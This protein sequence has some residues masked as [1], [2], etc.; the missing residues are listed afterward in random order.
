MTIWSQTGRKQIVEPVANIIKHCK[1]VTVETEC[2]KDPNKMNYVETCMSQTECNSWNHES[3]NKMY[4][5]NK[6]MMQT[7]YVR[8]ERTIAIMLKRN[9]G[10]QQAE[11]TRWIQA[12]HKQN[13]LLSVGLSQTMQSLIRQGLK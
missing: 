5:L 6:G 12:F 8:E 13:Q 10:L 1:K 7:E 2:K 4:K 9:T 11:C 3:L